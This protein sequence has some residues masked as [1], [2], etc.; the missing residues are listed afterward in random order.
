MDIHINEDQVRFDSIKEIIP[1][2]IGPYMGHDFLYLR[3]DFCGRYFVT[4]NKSSGE[5]LKNYDKIF[6]SVSDAR[7]FVKELIFEQSNKDC[8]AVTGNG[9]WGCD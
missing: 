5:E 1:I 8:A 7:E 3:H 6:N 9:R 2:S 4:R